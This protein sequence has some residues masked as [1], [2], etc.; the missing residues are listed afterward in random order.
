MRFGN[1]IFV[2]EVSGVFGIQ[3]QYRTQE[4]SSMLEEDFFV[5][6]PYHLWSWGD[7][8]QF[9]QNLSQKYPS[10][11]NIVIIAPIRDEKR[12]KGKHYMY[13]VSPYN[14]QYCF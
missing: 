6:A 1:V 11:K 12:G 4:Q 9:Y 8:S 3:T 10:I 5:L 14:G 7:V 2:S 13:S